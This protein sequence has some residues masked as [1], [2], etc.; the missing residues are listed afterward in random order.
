VISPSNCKVSIHY[1][2][3]LICS[4]HSNTH[5]ERLPQPKFHT[6]GWFFF[7]RRYSPNLGLGLPLWNSPFHFGFLALRQSVGLLGR[8]INSSQGLSTCTQ[9]PN[10]HALGGIRTHDPGFR[11][12][13][14]SA[15]FRP[16]GYRDLLWWYITTHNFKTLDSVAFVF[17]GIRPVVTAS[18]FLTTVPRNNDISHLSLSPIVKLSLSPAKG[19]R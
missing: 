9:T 6:V 8:V 5:R 11:A 15:C 7:L 19:W 1:R 4:H 18:Q 16:L 3:P 13:E 2:L 14:D 17:V 10:I 12:S